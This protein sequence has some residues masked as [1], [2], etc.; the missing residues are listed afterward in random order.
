MPG[1]PTLYQSGTKADQIVLT[2]GWGRCLTNSTALLR[3][4]TTEQKNVTTI[5]RP[6]SCCSAFLQ[7]A[8]RFCSSLTEAA[9]SL[10][11]GI[12]LQKPEQQY[13]DNIELKAAAFSRAAND[14]TVLQHFNEVHFFTFCIG[15]TCLHAAGTKSCVKGSY[16]F[17]C[18]CYEAL[19]GIA[20]CM[21]ANTTAMFS[22]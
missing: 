3:L 15:T 5:L 8:T 13:V 1:L 4:W 16:A 21:L 2:F 9:N 22:L 12:E 20:T 6:V 10:H 17:A 18:L 19:A 14:E 7:G 11:G